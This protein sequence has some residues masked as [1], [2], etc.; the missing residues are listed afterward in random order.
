[1]SRIL[2]VE[3]NPADVILIREALRQTGVPHQLDVAGDGVDALA[4]LHSSA[5]HPELILL[6][7]NLPRKDGRDVLK[8]IK[9]NGAL[10]AIPVVILT[11]SSSD[12]DILRSYELR[13]NS[14]IRKPVDLEQF[15]QIVQSIDEYWLGIVRLPPQGET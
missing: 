1:M 2:L 9:Q 15:T 8:E 5:R 7:L 11:T 10:S 12:E 6:D 4:R 3:D 14:Y 13:A